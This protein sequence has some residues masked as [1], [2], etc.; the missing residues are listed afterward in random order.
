M[1]LYFVLGLPPGGPGGGYGRV[2]TVI[3]DKYYDQH[4]NKY[5]GYWGKCY[6]AYVRCAAKE[7]KHMQ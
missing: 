4:C 1:I 3:S 6:E 2:R 7:L 5:S